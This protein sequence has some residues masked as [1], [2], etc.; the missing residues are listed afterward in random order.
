VCSSDLLCSHQHDVDKELQLFFERLTDCGHSPTIILPLLKKA[1]LKA[2][3]RIAYERETDDYVIN[4]DKLDTDDKVFFHLPF[5]P[6][7]PNSAA[8]QRIWRENI[9]SPLEKPELKDLKNHWGHKIAISKLTVAYS[10]G[11]NLGNL[12]SC[13]K[14][15]MLDREAIESEPRIEK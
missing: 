9:A 15:K 3:E 14:M 13:R 2:R 11:P 5:H 1:E 6:S 10:R 8:I 12:L 4:K 7:N